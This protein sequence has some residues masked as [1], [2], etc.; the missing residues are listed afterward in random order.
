MTSVVKEMMD[1][2]TLLEEMG[3]VDPLDDQLDTSGM[4]EDDKTAFQ[5][6]KELMVKFKD[7][8]DYC[9]YAWKI[10]EIP[11]PVRQRL[12]TM[13]QINQDRYQKM[14]LLLQKYAEEMKGA[15]I[16]NPE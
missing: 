8:C 13:D 12:I 7:F 16:K 6:M 10:Q 11:A 3:G 5:V 15:Y 14:Y 4:S 2:D 9:E 1:F